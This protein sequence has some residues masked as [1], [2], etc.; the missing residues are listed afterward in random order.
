MTSPQRN[1]L[2]RESSPYLLLHADNP[3]DWYAW[4]DEAFAAAKREDKPIFLSVGYSTCYWCH[5]MERECF[6]DPEIAAQMNAGFVSIKLD[7]EERPDVDEIYMAATQLLTRSG[8]WPNS[9]FLT[10]ELKPFFAGTYFP[11]SDRMGRPGF[12][13]VLASMREAWALRRNEVLD[14]ADTVAEA[15]RQQVGAIGDAE[16][17]ALPDASLG[18]EAEGLLSRRFDP[19]YGGFG[20]APKFPSPS[21]LFFLLDR[22]RS[23]SA[24]AREM[25]VTT[26]DRMARGGIHDQIAGGFHRY[27]TDAAW[28]VP[29]FEKMLYDNAALAALYADAAPLAPEAGFERV[30]RST[31]DF[32]LREMTG[33]E[34]GFWSAID[35]ETDGHEGAY[36]TWTLEDLDTVLDPPDRALL[37][38]VLGFAGPP[39]FEADRYVLHLP[40]PLPEAA[41]TSGLTVDALLARMEPGRLALLEARKKRKRP[42]TDDKVLTD[43]NGLMIGAMARAGHALKEP[44]YVDAAGAAAR[45]VAERLRDP[46][47]ALLHAYRDGTAKVPALLDDYAFLVDGLLALHAA[48]EE[49]RWLDEAVRLTTE[50]IARLW[51]G[52]SGGFYAAA[53]SADLLV[54]GRPAHDG[55]VASGNGVAAWNLLELAR[56]T[57]D[58]GLLK[59]ADELLRSLGR[60]MAEWP[61]GHLT[62]VRALGH[63][64]ARYPGPVAPTRPSE[65]P[66]KVAA[67]SVVEVRG[68]LG[69]AEGP[70]KPFRIELVI[71]PGWHLNANPPLL[72]FLVATEV[73]AR[74]AAV[75]SVR[76]PTA[77]RYEG[78][79]VIEGE[80]E[81]TGNGPVTVSLVYQPCDEERCLTAVTRDVE[82]R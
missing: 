81:T 7:R 19:E 46:S 77:E 24:E 29:H 73:K 69:S 64:G 71:E 2:A 72:R 68:S 80:V 52:A 63:P 75:R 25:L 14:Q 49:R 51:D 61:L 35:A 38:N 58:D 8:G 39:S 79:V 36:Y 26:L 17:G 37:G 5:V 23:G 30:A 12:P 33:P 57:G 62:L 55:A 42:L 34:G 44:R 74:E 4:G 47:G 9:V 18:A 22:A 21:N 1:R 6:S 53:E 56:L 70:W 45:F 78:T 82:I 28:L 59:K 40:A 43:W 27:S 3:V 16:P 67:G 11:P 32:V 54:R 50:Q 76:Y 31:L 65:P 13:R 48:T 20:S 66:L 41:R 15:I 10:H 60:L